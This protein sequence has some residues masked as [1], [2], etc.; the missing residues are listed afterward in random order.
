MPSLHGAGHFR[1]GLEL[2]KPPNALLGIKIM[3]TTEVAPIKK[4]KSELAEQ[5]SFTNDQLALMKNTVAKGVTDDEFLLFLHLAKTYGLDPFA[6]EIWCNR[7]GTKPATIFTSRDGYLKIASRD[8]QM[9]GIQSDT[10]CTNDSFKRLADG[11]IDHVYGLPDRGA[12]IGAWAL[13]H[14]KD[15]TYP[16]YF[17]APW[18]EYSAGNN[19][20]WK[21]YPSAMIIK[22]A[23]AM[24]LKRAFSISGLVTQEEIGLDMQQVDQDPGTSAVVVEQSAPATSDPAPVILANPLT[25]RT[26]KLIELGLQ[27]HDADVKGGEG[28]EAKLLAGLDTMTEEAG[29]KL[30]R[31]LE[32]QP[33]KKQPTSGKMTVATTNRPP[34]D[35]SL[36][37]EFKEHPTADDRS[38]V[39]FATAEQKRELERLVEVPVITRPEKTLILLNINRFDEQRAQEAIKKLT[40]AIEDREGGAGI[41]AQTAA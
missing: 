35:V 4:S 32:K 20:T 15:R 24:A 13:V 29:T 25:P 36:V 10:V 27:A 37:N 28:Y 41:T 5:I 39:Q 33:K 38:P 11:T 30:L 18:A 26:K 23:E 3:V 1:T 19:P 14:R 12:I 7:Y 9:N 16:A 22:V 17:Y 31:W 34:A 2:D 21:K 8:K 6:K 40:R